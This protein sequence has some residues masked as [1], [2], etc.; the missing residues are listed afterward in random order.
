MRDVRGRKKKK[1]PM[2]KKVR[3]DFRAQTS[4]LVEVDCHEYCDNEEYIF[5]KAEE[6]A[7]AELESNK[8]IPQWEVEDEGMTI[9]D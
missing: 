4:I 2:K 9:E 1:K 7:R 6:L 5:D 3:V 8:Y